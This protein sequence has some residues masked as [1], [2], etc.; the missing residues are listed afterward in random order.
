[1]SAE[2]DGGRRTSIAWN[3]EAGCDRKS[4]AE[5]SRPG[6]SSEVG[7]DADASRDRSEIG[8]VDERKLDREGIGEDNQTDS[9]Y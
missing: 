2:T 3:R 5:G 1:M 9:F 4:R 8:D 6:S 7:I